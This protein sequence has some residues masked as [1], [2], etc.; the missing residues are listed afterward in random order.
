MYPISIILPV[1]NGS[2]YIRECVQSVLEQTYTNFEFLIIDDCSTDD[3]YAY[4]QLLNDKR[5]TLF[6]NEKNR[7]LF[8]NLNF[9]INKSSSPLIKLWSQDDIMHKDCVEEIVKFHTLYPFL[10]FSYTG[11]DYI[12]GDGNEIIMHKPDSTPP[13]VSTALH[14]KI[15][16]IT[17][18]IAG[19]ISNVTIAKAALDKVGLFNEQMKISGDF[20]MWVRISKYY[21]IGFIKKPLIKLRNHKGQL[22]N[23]EQYFVYHLKED[24]SVYKYLF[25]YL[26]E[27]QRQEGKR[28][29]RNQKL[30]FYYTLMLKA[31]FKG[32]IKLAFEFFKMIA[33]FDNFFILTWFY[34]KHKL[35]GVKPVFNQ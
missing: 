11:R 3:S 28:M 25:S 8:Y 33:G 20:E 7:G 21:T 30:L 1:Y 19:N 2:R 6:K 31:G 10:G 24:I 14:A 17:G 4:L 35:F 16:F 5:I 29:L 32:R 23:Q 22:S 15:A 27:E 34:I 26:P 18:S 9:L 12:D 13:L